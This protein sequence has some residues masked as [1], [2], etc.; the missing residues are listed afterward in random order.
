MLEIEATSSSSDNKVALADGL[1][2]R[3][4]R[5][6]PR[7]GSWPLHAAGIN[8]LCADIPGEDWRVIRSDAD[9]GI[10]VGTRCQG[11]V[12]EAGDG[13]AFSDREVHPHD[14]RVIASRGVVQVLI[15]AVRSNCVVETPPTG[16]LRV[17]LGIGVRKSP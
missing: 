9:L 12:F 2:I 1:V 10:F 6:L 7:S 16:L 4:Y 5:S 8:L 11:Q 15:I 17:R 13:F 3:A 14:L